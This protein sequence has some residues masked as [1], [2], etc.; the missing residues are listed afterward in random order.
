MPIPPSDTPNETPNS[1]YRTEEAVNESHYY[2][3]GKENHVVK[4]L[5]DFL[6]L[7]GVFIVYKTDN[8]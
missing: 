8:P 1:I 2:I 6:S 3:V 5:F 7:L 4:I